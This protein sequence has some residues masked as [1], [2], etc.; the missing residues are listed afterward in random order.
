MAPPRI[1]LIADIG[2]SYVRGLIQGITAY[3]RDFGPWSYSLHHNPLDIDIPRRLRA[4]GVD[5]VLARIHRPEVGRALAR[6]GVPVVDLLE[7]VPIR[8][9]PQIVVDDSE[10]VR[11][12]LEH[13]I[14]RGLRAVA[15]LGLRSVRYS[16][17]RRR[18]LVEQCRARASGLQ[19]AP[20]GG[21]ACPLTL[22]IDDRATR[23]PHERAIGDWIETLPRPIGL[24]CCNDVWAGKA[25]SA[26]RN[27]DIA[28]PDQIAIVGV[29]DDPVVCQLS[30]TPLTSVDPNTFQIGYQ[31]ARLLHDM[32][33]GGPKPPRL[34]VVAPA[35]VVTRRST[36]VLAF[37]DHEVARLVRYVRDHACGGLTVARM[38]RALG[39][40]RRTLERAFARHLGHSPSDEIRHVRLMRVRQL[41]GDTDAGLDTIARLA[42]FSY[43]ESMRRAFKAEFGMSPK[44]YRS[45]QRARGQADRRGGR[46]DGI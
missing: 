20:T 2:G 35:G 24:V 37:P 3:G 32:L 22:L 5:G 39:T 46:G 33:T 11:L 42:G 18:H 30:A 27:R 29:D 23:R 40:S 34:N 14:E 21:N 15:Y 31:A 43:T 45:K 38:A 9:I 16:D 13:L 6:L 44:V 41:L 17:I 4:E 25:A 36:D 8:G 1:A 19:A 12:A 28:V 7:E 10:V 26:C